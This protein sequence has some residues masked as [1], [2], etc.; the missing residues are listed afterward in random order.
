MGCWDETD[1]LTLAPIYPNE[2]V[3]CLAFHEEVLNTLYGEVFTSLSYRHFAGSYGGTYD[4]YGGIEEHEKPDNHLYVF[5]KQKVWDFIV[6]FR[7]PIWFEQSLTSMW[8]ERRAMADTLR[9]DNPSFEPFASPEVTKQMLRGLQKALYVCDLFR[10]SIFAPQAFAGHQEFNCT[11]KDKLDLCKLTR[12]V[13][14]DLNKRK[15]D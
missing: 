11:V 14:L 4:Y 6:N 10:R 12:E 3:V 5:F 8:V 1:A 2:K 15:Y 9:K 13:V 7:E